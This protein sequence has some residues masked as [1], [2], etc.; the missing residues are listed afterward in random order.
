[1]KKIVV[2]GP[3]P[4]FKGGI[5]NYNTSLAK[6]LDR[7]EDVEVHIV[8]WTQQY[9]AIIPRDFID[10][11]SKADQLA[12]TGIKVHYLLNYNRPRS[13]KKTV[14]LIRSLEPEQ[15]IVQWA[16][17]IQ[18]IPL[19]YVARKLQKAG[20]RLFFD[21]HFVVQK[22]N[23]SL[24][25][26]LTRRCLKFCKGYI[27]HSL[28]TFDELKELIP[29]RDYKLWQ[30]GDPPKADADSPDRE[31]GIPVLKLYH[32]VYDMFKKDESFDVEAFK[33]SLGLKNHV[34]LFFGFI[35]KYKGLHNVIKAFKQVSEERDD[36]SLL[37]VGELFWSTLD[38]K[39][40]STRLKNAL[41]GV[42]KKIFL[43]KK[44]D[45]QN[46]RPLDLID[47]YG[48]QDKVVAITE[49]VPNED[50]HMYFQSSDSITLFYS[51]ATPSGVES[52]SYNFGLPILAAGVGHFRETVK[53][54]Y[55]G[56][57]AEPEDPSSMARV[58]LQSIEKPIPAGNVY[59]TSAEMSWDNY[60]SAILAN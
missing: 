2:F 13:W 10:R 14:K 38:T 49:F 58:M 34:F 31:R 36:V 41:F 32:P 48:L 12:G 53:H 17:A 46:Y 22:E 59:A 51:A 27:T 42:A 23:S 24:D 18:G 21:L 11:K 57:L 9:P 28:K 39:K 50:V 35:R 29:D 44:D 16:I 60:A 3:G 20:I 40:F 56:Y 52:M 54:G 8:S 55:N 1:M 43:S 15:V 4:Q 33:A 30:T 47:S 5:A 37:I 6:A 45:E 7:R 26:M 25:R 19:R